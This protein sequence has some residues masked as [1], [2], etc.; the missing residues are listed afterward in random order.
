MNNNLDTALKRM[1]T[2]ILFGSI[3]LLILILAVMFRYYI[4][5][6]TPPPQKKQSQYM[7]QIT[8]K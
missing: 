4:D 7:E 3:I 6:Q 8:N 2:N 5:K 1:L